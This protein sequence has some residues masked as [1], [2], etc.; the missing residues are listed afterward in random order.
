MR[1]SL[2]PIGRKLPDIAETCWNE[3]GRPL[4]GRLAALD[5]THKP[6]FGV[7][8]RRLASVGY[9]APREVSLEPMVHQAHSVLGRAS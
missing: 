1:T 6:L 8:R 3:I 5:V 4:Q 9:E 2:C 7:G